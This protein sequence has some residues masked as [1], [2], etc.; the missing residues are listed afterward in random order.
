MTG[1]SIAGMTR[2]ACKSSLYL[3]RSPAE[4]GV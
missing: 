3:E 4:E 2:R 1:L